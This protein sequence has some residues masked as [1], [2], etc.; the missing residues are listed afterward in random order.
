MTNYTSI[1]PANEERLNEYAGLS[2]SEVERMLESAWLAFQSWRNVR[3]SARL[4]MVS[5]LKAELEKSA[6]ELARTVSLEMG[7]VFTAATG[8]A[9]R[10]P[11]FCDL[12]LEQAEA[13]LSPRGIHAPGKRAF[14][15]FEPIGVVFSITP[16]NAPIATPFRNILPAVVAGNSV[17]LKPAPNVAGCAKLVVDIFKRSGFPDG[18]VSLA[19]LSN[20]QAEKVIADWRVRKL[21]FTGSTKVGA[22]L[23]SIAGA[24]VKPVM[25]ELGGSDPCLVLRD[26]DVQKVAEELAAS[27]CANAGQVCCSPKRILIE[28]SVL[29]EFRDRF[30]AAMQKQV[31]GDPFSGSTTMGPM[32]RKD[33]RD[34]LSRQLEMFVAKGADVLLDGGADKTANSRGYFFR[35]MVI[36]EEAASPLSNTEELFGPVG[37]LLPVEN[38]DEAVRVANQTRYGLGATVFTA[39]EKVA[40]D[41]AGRLEAGFVHV[42]CR[43]DLNP[44]IPF[45]GVKASGF[46][47]D[48]GPEGFLE[49]T[50]LKAIIRN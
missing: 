21:A 5:R 13:T 39:D 28:K 18:L 29:P 46:G 20:E 23:A 25:L 49:Y 31:V 43:P 3:L 11:A 34:N 14:S 24:N 4:Q 33:L 36:Q 6:D 37:V 16:W 1:N 40:D 44:Y 26:A 42:N 45:G 12:A 22:H 32:A 38:V 47:R 30:V 50:S 2:E 7:K 48:C 35:P 15:V 9:K 41:V 27:R 8:E 10:L 17:V 19:L